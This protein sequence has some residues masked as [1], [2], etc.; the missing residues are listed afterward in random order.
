LSVG[1]QPLSWPA[2]LVQPLDWG[3]SSYT[4]IVI[5]L[6]FVRCRPAARF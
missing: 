6:A 2:N 5:F 1:L 3:S 4:C